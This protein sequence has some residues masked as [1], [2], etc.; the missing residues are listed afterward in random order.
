FLFAVVE[1]AVD[2]L[3]PLHL[4]SQNLPVWKRSLQCGNFLYLDACSTRYDCRRFTNGSI[5]LLC[6]S[7]CDFDQISTISISLNQALLGCCNE[8]LRASFE[9]FKQV[10]DPLP[11]KLRV[12]VIHQKKRVLTV[13]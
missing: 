6:Y 3:I 5:D 12:H 11:I 9:V 4:C 7:V 2:K 13:P 10:I 1:I 8:R